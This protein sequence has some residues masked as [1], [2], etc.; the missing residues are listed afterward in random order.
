[1]LLGRGSVV[2]GD[3]KSRKRNKDSSMVLSQSCDTGDDETQNSKPEDD[4]SAKP[5]SWISGSHKR[6]CD[7]Y[8]FSN[9]FAPFRLKV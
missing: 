4:K 9:V 5:D 1:M 2:E 8:L 6:A 7:R 3:A